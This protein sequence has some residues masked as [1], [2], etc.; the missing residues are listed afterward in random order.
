M[1]VLLLTYLNGWCWNDSLHLLRGDS[2][3]VNIDIDL[4]RKANVKLIEHKH[5]SNI[6]ATKDTIIA[7]ERLKY[8]TMDSIYKVN[9]A[10]C[11]DN[12]RLLERQVAK[13]KR[14]N[15]ILGGRAHV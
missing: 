8:A 7:L 10:I 4:I 3:K 5:C 6:I 1:I 9:Y 15:K 14:K 13:S 11:Y 2:T 12:V